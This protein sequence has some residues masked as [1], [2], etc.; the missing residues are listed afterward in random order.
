MD[1]EQINMN[2]GVREAAKATP[3]PSRL[4]FRTA[5]F[6]FIE[7]KKLCPLTFPLR[8]RAINNL[9]MGSVVIENYLRVL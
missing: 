4:G 6:Q 2:E 1:I 5:I 7:K 9:Q 3:P 8:G